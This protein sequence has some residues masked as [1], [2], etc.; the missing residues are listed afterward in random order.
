MGRSVAVGADVA[1]RD[2]AGDVVA[3][4]VGAGDNVRPV[5]VGRRLA[6]AVAVGRVTREVTGV[7]IV[8]VAVGDAAGAQAHNKVTIRHRLLNR[9]KRHSAMVRSRVGFVL[10]RA[11]PTA[12]GRGYNDGVS[13]LQP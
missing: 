4:T 10:H 3:V 7:T 5:S 11:P 6:V 1:V 8:P 2:G 9:P 12:A 13:G